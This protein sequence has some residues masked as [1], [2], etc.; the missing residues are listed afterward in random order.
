MTSGRMLFI[1][2]CVVRGS[3]AVRQVA[4]ACVGARPDYMAAASRPTVRFSVQPVL[5]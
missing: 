2:G 3:S 5:C 1:A 4:R